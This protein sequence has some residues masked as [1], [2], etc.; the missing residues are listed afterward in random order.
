MVVPPSLTPVLAVAPPPQSYQ[1]VIGR[2]QAIGAGLN[3]NDGLRWFNRLYLE[4]TEA[5]A[6]AARA[7]RFRDPLFIERLDCGF[8]DLYFRALALGASNPNHAPGAWRPLLT[9]RERA[10]LAPVQFA[11]AGV[12]AHINRDLPVALVA[13]YLALGGAPADDS[14]RF[15]DYLKINEILESVQAAAKTWLITGVLAELDHSFG[16]V[17][18]VL[19]IW[20]LSRARDSAW[21]G[22][23]VRWFIRGSDFLSR[24]SLEAL[25]RTV[26][27]ASRGL[28]RP[29]PRILG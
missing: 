25:D 27:F 10:D 8:A 2:L 22:A 7:G 16:R 19:E 3:A 24:R 26:G 6:Q 17:D 14:D 23:N 20:S 5:V 11:L 4:M 29:L 18:D 12:N 9:C 28:L 13:T 21:I 1:E 15:H